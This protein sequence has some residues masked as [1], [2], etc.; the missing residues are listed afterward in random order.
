MQETLARIPLFFLLVLGCLLSS[1]LVTAADVREWTVVSSSGTV[2]VSA[3]ESGQ[4]PP[5]SAE[6]GVVLRAPFSVRTGNDGRLVI[7][8]GMDTITIGAGALIDVPIPAPTGQ[9]FATRIHQG[10]GSI[11]YEVEH[12]L[13]D[14]FEVHTPDHRYETLLEAGQVA[15]KGALR[16]GIRI[17]DQRLLSPPVSGEVRI[18]D[19]TNL[20]S[21]AS[22]DRHADNLITDNLVE[23]GDG[24]I[25]VMSHDTGIALD[26]VA[27]DT[28][29]TPEVAIGDVSANLGG[30]TLAI[31]DNLDTRLAISDTSLQLDGASVA[32]TALTPSLD[33]GE[34]DVTLGGVDLGLDLGSD[35]DATLDLGETSL[36]L[37]GVTLGETAL[38]PEIGLD[39]TSLA[40]DDG[41]ISLS[42]GLDA[43]IIDPIE[44][45]VGLDTSPVTDTLTDT[46]NDLGDDLVS[47][48]LDTVTGGLGL[49]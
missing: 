5:L 18:G 35:L 21:L 10:L 34:I 8:R 24:R 47:P 44:V 39:E 32:G 46:V 42:T 20:L 27:V 22:I 12:R 29:L 7:S 15:I 1:S 37:D 19:D 30:V 25:A 36:D 33:V 9:G 16:D 13:K 49:F 2:I 31:D 11:L 14:F 28:A 4:A 41:G 45:E 23:I 48:V 40:I 26:G 6:T 17:E 38:T 3:D 43:G